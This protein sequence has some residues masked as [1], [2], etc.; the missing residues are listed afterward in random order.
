MGGKLACFLFGITVSLDL[1]LALFFLGLPRG[2]LLS[3]IL[4]VTFV[5]SKAVPS[6]RLTGNFTSISLWCCSSRA[7]NLE[8]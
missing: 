6:T 8:V 5:L 4:K 3:G 7:G 2:D 1:D